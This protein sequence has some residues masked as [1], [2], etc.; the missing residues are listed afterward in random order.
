SLCLT[1]GLANDEFRKQLITKPVWTRK[2]MQV[3][4]KEFIHQE[5]VNRVVAATKQGD[6][7]EAL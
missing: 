7:Q 4:S 1:N 5:E 2:E 3:I 6:D